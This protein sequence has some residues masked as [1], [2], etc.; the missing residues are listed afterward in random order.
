[1]DMTHVSGEKKAQQYHI[2]I[3]RL[4]SLHPKISVYFINFLF[5]PNSFE[6]VAWMLSL[7]CFLFL[8]QLKHTSFF[9]DCGDIKFGPFKIMH[10]TI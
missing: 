2:W 6:L 9:I 4:Y 7:A 8:L 10:F 1:M 5:F 3:E